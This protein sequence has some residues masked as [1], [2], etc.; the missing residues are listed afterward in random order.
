MKNDNK[1]F[2]LVEL[3]IIIAIMGIVVTMLAA[4]LGFLNDSAAKGCANS[5]KTAIG[6]TRIKTMGKKET[7]L[8]VYKDGKGYS[9][10]TVNKGSKSGDPITVETNE[11]LAKNRV[12]VSYKF[13]QSTGSTTTP[14]EIDDSHDLLIGFNRENG[15]LDMDASSSITFD[16]ITRSVN[17]V[18]NATGMI[19]TVQSGNFIYDITV[20]GATGK[21]EMKK[22]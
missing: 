20:Y 16:G 5:L 6:Q 9:I 11:K 15:K 1:G 18:A 8:Y 4:N 13:S 10:K 12:T 22:R 17:T 19:I 21:V 14:V 7:Y 2:S 3:V